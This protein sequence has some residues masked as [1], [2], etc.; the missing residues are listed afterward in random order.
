MS[1]NAKLIHP[2]RHRLK[3]LPTALVLAGASQ[4]LACGQSTSAPHKPELSFHLAAAPH[5]PL[6]VGADLVIKRA[7]FGILATNAAGDEN[8]VATKEIPAE[9][10][11]AFGWVIAV[12]TSRQSLHWQEHLKLPRPP[13]DWGDAA[14]DPDITI[15][16]DGRTVVAE[17]DDLVEDGELSRFYWALAPGDPAGEYEMDIAIEGRQVGH[18]AFTVPTA[19]VEKSIL[20][21]HVPARRATGRASIIHVRHESSGAFRWK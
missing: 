19:V 8:F 6:R 14:T 18:V 4:F 11:Q 12:D 7:Q 17:G 15:A 20:V 13:A 5:L 16:S 3:Y 9:D 1:D 21:R 2:G 10:G